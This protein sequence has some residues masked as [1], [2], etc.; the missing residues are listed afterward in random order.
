[1]TE[2]VVLLSGGLDSAT[3][4]F[5]ALKE[6][7]WRCH[8][9]LFDYGQR[10]ARELDSAR[11]LARQ[12]RCPFQVIRFRLPWG[13]S[14]LLD[15][16]V[17]VPSHALSAIGRGAI[18]STYVPARNTIFL[19]FALSWAD[20]LSVEKIVLGANALDYSG[21]PDC[22]PRYFSAV[23][24]AGRLGTR[25]GTEGKRPIR[26]WAPLLRLTKAQIIRRGLAWGVPYEKTWSCYLGGRRPCGR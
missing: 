8:C 15:R 4:L 17:P 11:S 13:G 3:A 24:N 10:H 7:K 6:K 21:Y 20:I 19:S 25:L 18:P 26:I 9:L 12:M 16:R 22:R 23:Q 1:M 2:A 5:W 14:S